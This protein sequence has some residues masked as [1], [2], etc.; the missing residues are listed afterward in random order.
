PPPRRSSDLSA[1]DRFDD[2]LSHAIA[3]RALHRRR[4]HD[5]AQARGETHRLLGGIAAAVVGQPLD[6]VRQL[7]DAPEALLDALHQQ[8]TYVLGADPAGGGDKAHRLPVTAV[9]AEG[10][11][12]HLAV[13]AAALK[14]IRAPAQV[15]LER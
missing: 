11:P 15:A 1:R 3:L 6:R 12:H 5:K 13:P 9:Q 10:H 14:A 4:A 2:R 7:L 8:I